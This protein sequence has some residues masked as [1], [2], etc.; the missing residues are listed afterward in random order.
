M[1]EKS[2][3]IKQCGD[4]LRGGG[5][6][7][8]CRLSWAHK[9]LHSDQD[10]NWVGGLEVEQ[11]PELPNFEIIQ[12]GNPNEALVCVDGKPHRLPAIGYKPGW[13]FFWTESR[14][15]VDLRASL[16]VSESGHFV[17]RHLRRQI[18]KLWLDRA[19]FNIT[20]H[21]IQGF[22]MEFEHSIMQSAA[23]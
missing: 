3:T 23:T 18:L 10:K 1:G 19:G 9:G 16:L 21:F 13:D 2:M 12:E 14:T 22:I 11:P 6:T 8:Q 20:T 15:A 4:R 7:R 5:L 17:E